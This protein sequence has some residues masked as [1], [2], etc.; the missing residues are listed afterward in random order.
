MSHSINSPS[1]LSSIYPCIRIC[2]H[3]V[4]VS[5]STVLFIASVG[6]IVLV[7][8]AA[9]AR[10]C[11]E[12]ITHFILNIV[13][14]NYAIS[15]F[16]FHIR[17]CIIY[18]IYIYICMYIHIIFIINCYVYM[19]AVLHSG[20]SLLQPLVYHKLYFSEEKESATKAGGSTGS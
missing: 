1:L 10:K 7:L 4:R 17:I 2:K 18:I 19:S 6:N 12:L 3:E 15:S 8:V 16:I 9:V 5:V 11:S 20:P 14:Y 13:Y